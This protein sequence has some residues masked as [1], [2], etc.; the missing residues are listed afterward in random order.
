[1]KDHVEPLLAVPCCGLAN[2]M[3]TVITATIL[4]RRRGTHARVLWQPSEIC[5][6]SFGDL[7]EPHPS[8]EVIDR[9]DWRATDWGQMCQSNA[10]CIDWVGSGEGDDVRK[11]VKPLGSWKKQQLV[12]RGSAEATLSV[13]SRASAR[14]CPLLESLDYACHQ[15]PQLV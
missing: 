10:S 1:M 11:E 9:R 6:A 8:F 4:A 3:R 14:T 7:F 5:G 13:S 2:R 15:A 12:P